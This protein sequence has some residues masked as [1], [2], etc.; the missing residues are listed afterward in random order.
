MQG[1]KKLPSKDEVLKELGFEGEKKLPSK[2]EV[3]KKLGFE[4]EERLKE[5]EPQE[6]VNVIHPKEKIIT[7]D[8]ST[9]EKAERTR[10]R[11]LED[12]QCFIE[13]GRTCLLPTGIR[14]IHDFSGYCKACV[15]RINT[16]QLIQMQTAAMGGFA[17]MTGAI[18]AQKMNEK[19]VV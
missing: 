8:L 15:D 11:L 2:E 4:T 14:K 18:A 9:I 13:P 10:V 5:Q 12:G 6:I 1:E 17:K 7:L 19:K 16:I 3:L